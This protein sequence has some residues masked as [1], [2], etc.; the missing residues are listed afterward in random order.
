MSIMSPPESSSAPRNPASSLLIL[1][2]VLSL[3]FITYLV[4]LFVAQ[5]SVKKEAETYLQETT[6]LQQ[7]ADLLRNKKV[8]YLQ[9]AKQVIDKVDGQRI[10]WS[11][12]IYDALLVLPKDS[13][14]GKSKAEFL[15]YSGSVDGKLVMS[16]KTL[17]GSQ[18]PYGDVAD[19]VSA[20]TRSP[21][22]SNVFVPTISKNQNDQGQTILTY[23][24]NLTYH[25]E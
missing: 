7:Q 24:L 10:Y 8:D 4:Y 20:F 14:T 18:N 1:A 6:S 3:L 23:V 17:A 9:K 22:F 25:G 11:K 21:T 15:S 13:K 2:V 16:A 12:V 5:V 19:V